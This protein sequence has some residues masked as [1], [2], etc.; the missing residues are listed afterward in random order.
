[1]FSKL[2]IC[3]NLKRVVIYYLTTILFKYKGPGR[4]AVAIRANNP[5][6]RQCGLF[7]FE[8]DILDKGENGYVRF[9][10]TVIY[11]INVFNIYL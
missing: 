7:Y 10:L 9:F 1:M 6:P 2:K 8:I 11:G 5:I 4:N 3:N